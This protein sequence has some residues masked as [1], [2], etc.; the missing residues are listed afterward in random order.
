MLCLGYICFKILARVK[1][2]VFLLSVTLILAVGCVAG[3]ATAYCTQVLFEIGNGSLEE[4][5]R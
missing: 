3:I 2:R 1:E 4:I 5:L